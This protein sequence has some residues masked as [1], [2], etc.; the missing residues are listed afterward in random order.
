MNDSVPEAPPSRAKKKYRRWSRAA[1]AAELRAIE[2]SG[3]KI[4]YTELERHQG[5]LHAIYKEYGTIRAAIDDAGVRYGRHGHKWTPD[6]VVAELR[7]LHEQGVPMATGV[8]WREHPRLYCGILVVFGSTAAALEAAGLP[9]DHVGRPCKW[10]GDMVLEEIRDRHERGVS[11]SPSVVNSVEA[12]LFQA[13][14]RHFG[15]WRQAVEAAGIHYSTVKGRKGRP[16]RK[17][18]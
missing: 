17:R 7:L 9:R 18:D 10:T 4:T 16:P 5:L 3:T 1:I 6:M 13:A 14:I 8:L 2:A 15:G 12:G 11:L